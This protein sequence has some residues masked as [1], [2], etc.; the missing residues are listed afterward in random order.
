MSNR[1]RIISVVLAGALFVLVS[2]GGILGAP[3]K[4]PKKSPELLKDGKKLYEQNC[5]V[6]HGEKGDGK[7]PAGV[8]LKP[9]PSD[10]AAPLSNWPNTKGN[11]G[12]VFEVIS[13]GIPN[14]AMVKWD[15]FSEKERWGLVYYVMEF[16]AKASPSGK[17]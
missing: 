1:K 5:V 2:A 8:A 7:G 11:P 4:A 10:F 15:Q 9:S 3:A 16:S 13:K 12:K 6:C 14:S 17:K